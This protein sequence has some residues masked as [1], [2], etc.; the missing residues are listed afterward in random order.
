MRMAG[1]SRVFVS[2]QSLRG[3]MARNRA[4]SAGR[5][6]RGSGAGRS[7]GRC[8]VSMGGGAEGEFP[9]T[10]PKHG[11][12][13]TSDCLRR[14]TD[15]ARDAALSY[16]LP[17]PSGPAQAG[18]RRLAPAPVFSWNSATTCSSVRLR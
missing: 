12:A 7:S 10:R 15:L 11:R 8:G 17:L 9:R 6:S 4:A 1:T 3:E 13:V 2:S 16:F 14:A 18:S 5:R